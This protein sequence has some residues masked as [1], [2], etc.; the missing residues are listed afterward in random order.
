MKKSP[1]KNCSF[2]PSPTTKPNAANSGQNEHEAEFEQ[3]AKLLLANYDSFSLH[4]AL[5][6]TRG[7][8]LPYREVEKL[9]GA[10]TKQLVQQGKLKKTMGVY[11]YPVFQ[12]I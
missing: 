8:D 2:E 4:D 6:L 3:T 1:E 7:L 11:N 5:T 10:W 9:F 12:P